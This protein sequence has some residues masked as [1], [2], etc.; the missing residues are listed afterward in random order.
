MKST[1]FGRIYEE[2][3][4]PD[5]EDLS[6]GLQTDVMYVDTWVDTLQKYINDVTIIGGYML[7]YYKTKEEDWDDSLKGLSWEKS[8]KLLKRLNGSEIMDF[9][10]SNY[11]DDMFFIGRLNENE[12]IYFWKHCSGRCD[13]CKIWT[14]MDED[15]LMEDLK[16]YIKDEINHGHHMDFDDHIVQLPKE[17]FKNCKYIQ[18]D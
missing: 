17:F 5:E 1:I 8:C 15:A 7:N 13:I 12:I 10:D 6:K 9:S 3:N 14:N 4:F 18:L 2:Y 16:F 11:F